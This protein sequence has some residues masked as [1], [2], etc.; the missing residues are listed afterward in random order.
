MESAAEIFFAEKRKNSFLFFILFPFEAT[1]LD[2][3]LKISSKENWHTWGDYILG[4]DLEYGIKKLGHNVIPAFID[5]FYPEEHTKS[6]IDIYM[7]GFVSFNP[8]SSCPKHRA[9]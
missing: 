6:Q 4:K 5:N 3:G 8:I 9:V 1:A 2:V 7:H